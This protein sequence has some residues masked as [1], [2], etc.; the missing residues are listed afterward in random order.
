MKRALI[1]LAGAALACE[2]QV[3]YPDTSIDVAV[4]APSDAPALT[5]PGPATPPP[6]V[7][8]AMDYAGGDGTPVAGPKSCAKDEDC[9][10]AGNC[11][12]DAPLGCRCAKA[13]D[14]QHCVAAC[15]SAADCPQPPG[16]ALICGDDGLCR[17][18]R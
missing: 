17:P 7:P 4:A 18:E 11:F 13:P 12:M 10:G 6:D 8:P 2:S 9:Q 15:Q 5:D 16:M 14:G 3:S 1:A